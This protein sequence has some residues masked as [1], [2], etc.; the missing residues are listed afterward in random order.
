MWHLL[1]EPA[2]SNCQLAPEDKPNGLLASGCR[3]KRF[4]K[5]C[6]LTAGQPVT[7]GHLRASQLDPASP[8]CRMGGRLLRHIRSQT[9]QDMLSASD[10]NALMPEPDW[11][12]SGCGSFVRKGRDGS[13]FIARSGGRLDRGT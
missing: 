13:A 10:P 4:A 7:F 2:A 8:A 1:H 9:W 6:L 11:W 12:L 3:L 5:A